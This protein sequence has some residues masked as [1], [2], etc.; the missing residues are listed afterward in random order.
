[1]KLLQVRISAHQRIQRSTGNLIFNGNGNRI[2]VI[3]HHENDGK[4]FP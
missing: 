2:A 3:L 4:L 1:M